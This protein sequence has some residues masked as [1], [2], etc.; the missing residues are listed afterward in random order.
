MKNHKG[1]CLT[2]IKTS[3]IK[4]TCE[5]CYL[6]ELRWSCSLPLYI[7][8]IPQHCHPIID[9]VCRTLCLIYI[10]KL[11]EH[12]YYFRFIIIYTKYSTAEQS[13]YIRRVALELI[14]L[15]C[16]PL[17][18]TLDSCTVLPLQVVPF[19]SNVNLLRGCERVNETDPDEPV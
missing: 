17:R 2:G 14:Q 3:T 16:K 1:K 4:S 18:K 19:T 9:K 5:I 12:N 7:H 11:S 10:R 13:N 15:I 6:V 8:T